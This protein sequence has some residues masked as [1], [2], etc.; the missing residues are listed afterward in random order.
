MAR[1]LVVLSA[2]CLV[3]DAAFTAAQTSLL[4][5]R[6]WAEHGWPLIV[7]TTLGCSIMGALV[8]G[9]RPGH[10]IGR[11]LLVAGLCS[12][13]GPAESYSTW[14]LDAGGP[15][16][17][18]AGHLA[19]WLSML[20]TAPLG[21]TAVSLIYLVAPDGRLR[22][23]GRRW[24]AVTAVL[25]L[26]LWL[27]GV[28]TL[29][30]TQVSLSGP[31]SGSRFF[32]V[33]APAG[34]LFI[35]V[36]LVVAAS[37]LLLRV[38]R[39]HG[40]ARRQLLWIAASATLIAGAL[41]PSLVLWIAPGAD[42]PRALS[43]LLYGSYLTMPVFTAVAV[44]RHRMLEIDVI[45]S[46][47]LAVALATA[48]VSAAYVL[49]VVLLGPLLSGGAGWVTLL[50]TAAIALAF[51]PLRR[52]VVRVADRLAYGEAA[53]PYEALADFSRRLGD[54]PDPATVLPAVADAAGRA[55]GADRVTA[56]AEGPGQDR[57]STWPVGAASPGGPV[58][59]LEICDDERLGS[60]IVEVR[61]GRALRPADLALLH[62]LAAAAA[63]ALRSVRLAAELS[64][65]VD[66][67]AVRAVELEAS[68]GR[69]LSAG[70]AQR[71]RLE[72]ALARD[73][74]PH[75]SALP[76]RLAQARADQAG[77]VEPLIASTVAALDALRA[78]TRGV[79]PAQ[80][81]RSGLEPSL[82]SL[83]GQDG[84][85]TLEVDPVLSGVRF[86]APVEAAAHFCV[87]EV[88]RSLGPPVQVQLTRHGPVLQVHVSGVTIGELPLAAVRD[89]VEAVGGT[90][91]L[92]EGAG[93]VELLAS[94][95]TD[96]V[97]PAQAGGAAADQAAVSAAGPSADL[98]K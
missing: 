83:L 84:G 77:S 16:P 91:V 50:T 82:R 51:Q 62:D 68:R 47:A 46:R 37:S 35:A 6:T 18:A 97:V 87:A 80:L 53:V 88:V 29:S 5:E 13:S 44:L 70:E 58:V 21:L 20:F 22:S 54:S 79:H 41:A 60:L 78:I 94:L 23:R 17:Q 27:I 34:F 3:L 39:A 25:G 72:L 38:R 67:L 61:P 74:L 7:L 56:R 15:G 31:T 52:R 45:V 48:L 89:R 24:A 81:T 10:P 2:V 85:A 59:E 30:P 93:R 73:V 69:L 49:A 28:A 9:Q 26:A 71:D 63:V 66:E 14:V 19:A 64:D 90:V 33:V 86:A 57:S 40:D 11:L 43:L 36:S 8:L 65:R 95:P 55:V 92:A 1:A 32:D 12:I 75:L 96:V 42:P 98:V 4:S 76:E